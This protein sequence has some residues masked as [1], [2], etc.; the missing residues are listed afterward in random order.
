LK[1]SSISAIDPSVRTR[2]EPGAS[3]DRDSL[4]AFG[5]TN[6]IPEGEHAFA[7]PRYFRMSVSGQEFQRRGLRRKRAIA[8][9]L[10][11]AAAAVFLLTLI[12][13]HPGFW[14]LLVRATAEAA[15]VG[16]LADWFAVTALFRQPLGLPI[17][18]TAIVP[19]N[20]D[21][22]GEGLAL[23]IEHNFLSPEIVRGKLRAIDPARLLAD[24]LS[25][26]Q[27]ADAVALR[28]MRTVPHL[29]GAA[30]AREFRDL[31]AE[32]LS[33]R[34][35][36]IELAP[37]LGQAVAVFAANRFHERLLDRIVDI[38]RQ[39]L[40]RREE[41]LYAAAEA[42][43]RRW[44]IPKAI[45]RQIAKAI[46]GGVKELLED[47]RE[48][49]R[50]ARQSLLQ[51]IERLAADL[52][53]SP[54]YRARVEEAKLQLLEDPQA[55]AWLGMLWGHFAQP[56]LAELASPSPKLR[57][58]LGAAIHSLGQRLHADPAMQTRLNRTL[59]ALATEV[60]PWRAQ[61]AQFIMEVVRQWDIKSFTERLELAVGRD[62][63]Y[64]RINGT[65][66]GA[67]VGS[68]LYLLTTAL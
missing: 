18:H 26:P 17:P 54:E 41:H 53:T 22:I 50:Q 32:A 8:T 55:K 36:E 34:L 7:P 49:S 46:V 6:E 65:L 56:I 45:N 35:K 63:Q 38:C 59:E 61:L 44:W 48:P 1:I 3:P 20:K 14:A 30:D 11:G 25:M 39:F 24:W 9:A 60:I 19:K 57:Q 4:T 62:L 27:T 43:R 64:I 33:R 23:F 28:L 68:L 47:V 40:E 5:A 31:A 52:E 42:Q 58:N 29:V 13:P 12:V 66:V 15:V 16:A 21:R 37:L 2:V 10:L 67:I 51:A